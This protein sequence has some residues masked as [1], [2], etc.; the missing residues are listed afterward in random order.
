MPL[1]LLRIR[2]RY[3]KNKQPRYQGYTTFLGKEHVMGNRASTAWA[4]LEDKDMEALPKEGKEKEEIF[5]DEY[6]T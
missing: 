2:N 3:R 1:Y 6:K 5:A 4:D